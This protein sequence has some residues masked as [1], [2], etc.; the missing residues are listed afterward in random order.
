M[1]LALRSSPATALCVN[2]GRERPFKLNVAKVRTLRNTDLLDASG[3]RRGVLE[4]F[5]LLGCYAA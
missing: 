1:A 2:D 5:A 3:F 4:I